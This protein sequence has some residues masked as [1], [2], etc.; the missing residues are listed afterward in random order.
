[1]ADGAASSPSL[2]CILAT[3]RFL[4]RGYPSPRGSITGDRHDGK[5]DSQPSSGFVPLI[6]ARLVSRPRV[7]VRY[8]LF[9]VAVWVGASG[10]VRAGRIG[11]GDRRG[12]SRVYVY[13]FTSGIMC[14]PC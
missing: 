13:I 10:S 7:S 14:N 12:V 2:E 11:G 1:M 3:S 8:P 9:L 5:H 6:R 4:R